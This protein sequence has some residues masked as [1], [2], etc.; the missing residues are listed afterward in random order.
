HTSFLANLVIDARSLV[1]ALM[2]ALCCGVVAT[3]SQ[4][5]LHKEPGFHRFFVLLLCFQS[6][7]SLVALGGSV[8][9]LFAGWELIGVSSALLVGFFHERASPVRGALRVIVIY[10]ISDAAMLS[11]AIYA[12]HVVG[13]GEID[14]LFGVV[15]GPGALTSTDA[16]IIAGLL[17]LATAGKCAQLPFSGWLPRALEGPTPSSGLFYGALSLHAGCFLLLKSAGILERA[18]LVALGVGVMG[19]L[20]ALYATLVGRVQTD[21]KSSLAFAAL[22]QVGVILVEIALGLY[23]LAMLH[24]VGHA[25][26]RLVQ[27]LRAPTVLH[28]FHELEDTLGRHPAPT[29]RHLRRLIPARAELW[30]YRFALERGYLD[31]IL[32]VIVVAHLRRFVRFCD[33]CERRLGD[34]LAGDAAGSKPRRD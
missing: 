22:T 8:E 20:T 26:L 31:A 19:A 10:R 27:F 28:D 7:M 9:V 18:P 16:T 24:I 34:L 33:R 13:T 21:I 17:A 25:A 11:A 2:S 5:Y 30:L 3:F 14:V 4:R 32:E 12:H 6:G 29:G 1:F 15:M 23:T